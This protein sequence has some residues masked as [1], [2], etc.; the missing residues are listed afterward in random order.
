[1]S[2]YTVEIEPGS[3][4]DGTEWDVYIE[5]PDGKFL[6]WDGDERSCRTCTFTQDGSFSHFFAQIY[7]RRYIKKH[8]K[9]AARIAKQGQRGKGSFRVEV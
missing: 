5:T 4:D 9:K 2:T 6:D 7:A 3:G 1:M 8:A